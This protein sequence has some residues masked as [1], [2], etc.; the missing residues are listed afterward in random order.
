MATV[1]D[2]LLQWI[3]PPYVGQ[4]VSLDMHDNILGV[5]T[6]T[7]GNAHSEWLCGHATIY[8]QVNIEITHSNDTKSHTSVILKYL[9]PIS[10]KEIYHGWQW[11]VPFNIYD[12]VTLNKNHPNYPRYSGQSQN[13][14]GTIVHMRDVNPENW[15][16]KDIANT[17]IHVKWDNGHSNAYEITALV[18]KEMESGDIQMAVLNSNKKKPTKETKETKDFP[19][20]IKITLNPKHKDFDDFNRYLE[21]NINGIKVKGQ[22]ASYSIILFKKNK[23]SVILSIEHSMMLPINSQIEKIIEYCFND[24]KILYSIGDDCREVDETVFKKHRTIIN[25]NFLN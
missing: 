12:R 20:G 11:E 25:T 2:K 9:T 17:Q 23:E 8:W 14:P 19:V 3:N 1:E 7:E 10:I 22:N 21:G 15:I 6:S 13:T 5:I 4:L 24:G 18:P 16:L